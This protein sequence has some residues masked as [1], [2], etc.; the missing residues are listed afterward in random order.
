MTSIDR[1]LSRSEQLISIFDQ[2]REVEYG[3]ERYLVRDNG[4]VYRRNQPRRKARPL[5]NIWTF[6]RQTS[7][8]GYMLIAG[9]PVHRIVCSAFHGPSPSKTHVVDHVDTNRANNRAENLRWL[10]AG[11]RSAQ[12]NFRSAD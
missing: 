6:G 5:D 1:A 8:T 11:K 2:E 10:S 3:N 12:S 7:V 4:A 9:V